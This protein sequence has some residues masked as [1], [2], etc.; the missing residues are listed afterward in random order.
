MVGDH[1]PVGACEADLSEDL[2]ALV[3]RHSAVVNG[4]QSH[5][6]FGE[7]KQAILLHCWDQREVRVVC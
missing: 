4:H 3:G 7:G 6:A 2:T 1:Q 5:L